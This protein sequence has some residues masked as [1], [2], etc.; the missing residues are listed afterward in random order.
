M[1]SNE[2]NQ[3]VVDYFAIIGL[4][5]NLSNK[6]K[7]TENDGEE[8]N[9]SNSFE[10][11]ETTG[12]TGRKL[13]YEKNDPIVELAILDKTLNE[14]VPHGFE[15]LWLT[16]AGHSANLNYSDSVFKTHHELFLCIRR[17][18][19][20][21]PI[22]DIGVFYEGGERV[23]V[24]CDII[25]KT[26]GNNSANLNNSSFTGDR[27]FITYRR[28]HELACNSLAVIDVTVIIKSKVSLILFHSIIKYIDKRIYLF[29]INFI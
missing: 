12:E 25:T 24:G 4:P 16:K 2:N 27:I 1:N 8:F 15:C 23:M 11:N 10:L 9:Y 19:D 3:R 18:R 29:I 21:P 13:N 22:T 5:A 26:V 7:N 14:R 6:T 20:K 17:G 28:S